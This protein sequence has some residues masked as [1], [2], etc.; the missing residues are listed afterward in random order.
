MCRVHIWF[1]S[2]CF[3]PL[4]PTNPQCCCRLP[5]PTVE[6][7]TSWFRNA[8]KV[9]LTVAVWSSNSIKSAWKISLKKH[10]ALWILH[11]CSAFHLFCNFLPFYCRLVNTTL[12]QH[13]LKTKWERFDKHQAQYMKKYQ[14]AP[15]LVVSK[16]R[17]TWCITMFGFF[18][19]TQRLL[20]IQSTVKQ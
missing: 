14:S 6:W 13:W 11:V 1:S 2:A 15:D 3:S 17:K 12:L 16:S 20:E 19:Y 5:T 18:H 8:D 4:W 7:R 10:A 9:D